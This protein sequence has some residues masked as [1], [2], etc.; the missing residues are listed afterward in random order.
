MAQ[1][2][3]PW[4][5]GLPNL[6]PCNKHGA[7]QRVKT[8]KREEALKSQLQ[9]NIVHA[10]LPGPTPLL[11]S[12]L[13]ICLT[14]KIDKAKKV[15]DSSP[16]Y[17]FFPTQTKRDKWISPLSSSQQLNRTGAS[18]STGYSTHDSHAFKKTRLP[19]F[20]KPTA[21]PTER[22]PSAEETNISGLLTCTPFS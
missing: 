12:R 11:L 2:I 14:L 6:L 9:M 20:N 15:T 1:A 18:P 3:Y 10:W 7:P 8:P 19:A 21:R 5:K 16:L 17:V 13:K 22:H 4:S